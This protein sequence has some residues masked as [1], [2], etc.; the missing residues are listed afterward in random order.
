MKEIESSD[1]S[2]N[3]EIA[4]KLWKLSEDITGVTLNI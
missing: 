2:N 4:K 3:L 1:Y